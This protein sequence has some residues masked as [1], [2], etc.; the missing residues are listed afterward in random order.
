MIAATTKPVFQLHCALVACL[1]ATSV[2]A[3][4]LRD[5]ID[6]FELWNDCKPIGLLVE[7]LNDDA[8]KIGLTKK[9]IETAV[10]SRLRGARIY[11]DKVS[12]PQLYVSV[13][14]V[15]SAYS[16]SLNFDKLV[17]DPISGESGRATTW[18]TGAAGTHGRIGGG[19]ILNGIRG[20]VDEFIDEYLR[21]NAKAC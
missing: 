13:H 21:V 3:S 19:F 12:L 17:S 20:Y 1:W 2:N 8:E 16:I 14:V 6:R 11:D 18:R 15:G 5:G 7:G 10:R 9:A 4:E